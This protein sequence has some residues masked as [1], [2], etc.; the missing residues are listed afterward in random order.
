MT[1][2]KYVF[3]QTSRERKRIARGSYAKKGGSR[4]KRC[5]LPSD[6]LTAKQRKELNGAVETIS[7]K[8]KLARQEW[9]KLSKSMKRQY[10]EILFLEHNARIKDI[11][12]MWGIGQ[13]NVWRMF[14]KAGVD[15]SD[16]VKKSKAYRKNSPSPEW[17]AFMAPTREEK[18]EEVSPPIEK[19]KAPPAAS[20]AVK[21]DDSAPDTL[22][23]IRLD[24]VSGSIN[25][26]GDPYAV[27]EKAL[28]AIDPSKQYH[29]QIRFKEVTE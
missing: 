4:S 16:I 29:I 13:N 11:A 17:L 25:Y 21:L 9:Q 6:N 3:D 2:E 22:K 19:P 12:E 23:H 5:S 24:V 26:I 18:S 14:N 10:L 8:Q 27:F 28:L 7:K 20:D 1:D 15:V